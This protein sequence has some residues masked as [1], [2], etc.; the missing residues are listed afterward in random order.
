M[1]EFPHF[2]DLQ[3]RAIYCVLAMALGVGVIFFSLAHG[4]AAT[5][6]TPAVT[7]IATPIPIPSYS[8]SP[9]VLPKIVVDVAGKV[10]HPGIYRLP[11]GS[12]AIDAIKAAG[13]QLKGVTLTDINL[14]EIL[15]DG[16][17]IIVGAPVI[18]SSSSKPKKS[19][20]P[21]GKI[22]SGTIDINTASVAQFEQL[23]GVGAVM[24]ARIFAYRTAHGCVCHYR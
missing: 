19:S 21:K 20:T 8:P 17:Q 23:P 2:S 10:L 14:A 1:F 13:K 22:T 9:V 4:N 5:P 18:T 7:P 15:S 6:T 11:V 3:R 12:R 16:E 24:A